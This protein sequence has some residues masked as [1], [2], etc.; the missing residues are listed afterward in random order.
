MHGDLQEFAPLVRLWWTARRFTTSRANVRRTPSRSMRQITPGSQGLTQVT[1]RK[2]SSLQGDDLGLSRARHLTDLRISPTLNR[3]GGPSLGPK[4][5][6]AARSFCC[7]VMAPVRQTAGCH[8]SA[9]RHDYE[10]PIPASGLVP[11][12][13][14]RPPRRRRARGLPVLPARRL[15]P[16]HHR[17]RPL[18]RIRPHLPRLVDR[19]QPS[20][21]PHR[22]GPA[23]CPRPQPPSARTAGGAAAVQEVA[24]PVPRP[25]PARHLFGRGN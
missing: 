11:G 20:A 2:A 18:R 25:A 4:D 7:S 1:G 12:W 6:Y 21:G 9:G 17:L 8:W 13:D 19:R 24:P 15:R 10:V 14:R 16:D 3:V 22:A 23:G 5:A